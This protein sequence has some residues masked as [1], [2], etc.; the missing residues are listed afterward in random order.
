[1]TYIAGMTYW[2]YEQNLKLAFYFNSTVKPFDDLDVQGILSLLDQLQDKGVASE[3]IDTS[4]MSEGEVQ[5]AYVRAILPSVYRKY[6]VRQIFGSR[7]HSGWLF[8]K[9]V[10]ALLVYDGEGGSPSDVYPHEE[11]NSKITIHDFL[12]T[13]WTQACF[14]IREEAE[15]FARRHR[16]AIY[17]IS[18]RDRRETHPDVKDAMPFVVQYVPKKRVSPSNSYSLDKY[19]NRIPDSS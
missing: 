6:R 12:T 5:E 14:P 9:H 11:E 7:R 8:G 18:I 17:L 16:E 2:L 1:M 19:G 10:P 15:H 3:R 4:K 13:P